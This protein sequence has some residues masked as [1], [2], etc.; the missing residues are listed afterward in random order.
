MP[1]FTAVAGVLLFEVMCKGYLTVMPV[2][3]VPDNGIWVPGVGLRRGAPACGVA[4]AALP[5]TGLLARTLARLEAVTPLAPGL[6]AAVRGSV[7]LLPGRLGV[8]CGRASGDRLGAVRSSA[9]RSLL[10]S[11]RRSFRHAEKA[12]MPPVS[13]PEAFPCFCLEK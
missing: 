12:E 3:R 6:C 13:P 8:K 10:L 11:S 9:P 7:G 4:D 2:S 5:W 1:A